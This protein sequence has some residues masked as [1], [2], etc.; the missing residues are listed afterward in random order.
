MIDDSELIRAETEKYA[1]MWAQP[2]YRQN[3]PGENIIP[4]VWRHLGE[5]ERATVTD[6]G[7]GEGRVIN[8]LSERGAEVNGFDLVKLHPAVEEA[9]LWTLPTDEQTEFGVCFDVLEHIPEQHVSTV[10]EKMRDRTTI[11]VAFT[12]ATVPC[13][14]G[15][16]FGLRLHETV[17]PIEW[18]DKRVGEV[19]NGFERVETDREWRPLYYGWTDL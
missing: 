9:C 7:A 6:Y 2:I 14:V 12:V 4:S 17:R 3:S 10:L 15:K 5:P 16:R 13:S 8:W 11:C 1:H 18:W 19:F